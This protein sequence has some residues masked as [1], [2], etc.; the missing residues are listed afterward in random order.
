MEMRDSRGVILRKLR[1]MLD[2]GP[3]V[4]AIGG[5]KVHFGRGQLHEPRENAIL[6]VRAVAHQIFEPIRKQSS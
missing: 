3:S 6:V 2:A 4:L 1:K 5:K